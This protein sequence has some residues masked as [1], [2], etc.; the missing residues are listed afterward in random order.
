VTEWYENGPVGL[1]QGFTLAHR[2]GTAN[3]QPPTLELEMKG[4]LV[5]AL[6]PGSKGLALRSKDGEMVLRYTGLSARDATGRELR[7][8]LEVRG[9]RLLVRVDDDGAQ[10]RWW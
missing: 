1:E 7:S 2:P 5:A 3:G 10:Y 9:E 8:W 6:E 4:D